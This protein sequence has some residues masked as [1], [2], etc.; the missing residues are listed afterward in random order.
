MSAAR[1][2][3]RLPLA[4]GALGVAASVTVAALALTRFSFEVPDPAAVGPFCRKLLLPYPGITGVLIVLAAAVGT[5]VL[6]RAARSLTRQLTG[7][8]RFLSELSMLAPVRIAD[9][10]V[11]RVRSELPLAFCA[12]FIA[13]RIYLSTAAEALLSPPEIDA[14]IAHERHHQRRR[15]PLRLL[16][17]RTLGHAVFFMPVLRQLGERYAALAEIAADEA[18]VRRT[19]RRTLAGALLSFGQRP[20]PAFVMGIDPRRVDH[21]LGQSARWELP[22]SILAGSLVALGALIGVGLAST[23][24]VAGGSISLVLLAARS[25]ML[26]MA[27]LPVLALLAAAL[28]WRPAVKALRGA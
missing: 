25:C 23:A 11:T 18:A 10:E 4:L 22:V 17:A 1:R 20:G 12:G 9:A 14:V 8:R 26:L 5:L 6:I 27:A 21:L 13:P 24:L 7:Q 3:Y 16:V 15:D 2:F 19:D 28:H